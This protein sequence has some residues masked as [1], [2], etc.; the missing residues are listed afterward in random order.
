[1]TED[2]AVPS[3]I[4]LRTMLVIDRHVGPQNMERTDG[5]FEKVLNRLQYW[6]TGCGFLVCVLLIKS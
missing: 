5:D 3:F 2:M 4:M 6:S 1:M